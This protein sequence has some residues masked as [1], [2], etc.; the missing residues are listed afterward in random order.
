MI[1]RPDQYV[2]ITTWSGTAATHSITGLNFN[3][4]PDL[5][6]LKERSSTSDNGLWN[7][8]MGQSEYN[9]S[10]AT[11][12][13]WDTTTEFTSFDHNGFTLGN[14]TMTNQ[15]GQTYVA[16]CWRAGGSKGTFN[17]D[18]VAYPSA[19]A[20]GLDG[21]SLDPSGASIGTKQGFSILKYSGAS[22]ANSI[23][24]G[25]SQAP[26]FIIVKCIDGVADQNWTIYHKDLPTG[27]Y[28]KFTSDEKIDYPMFNDST[29]N[30][31][32]IPLGNDDQVSGS[33]GTY[34]LYAWHDVPGLQ[35]FGSYAGTSGK[36]F[37]ELGFRP[38]LLVI[39]FY[40]GTD[41]GS[42]A[43]WKVIDSER[44]KFNPD[45]IA[46]KLEWNTSRNENGGTTISTSEG[47]VDFLSNGFRII[48]NHAP[49]NSSGRNY[50]YMAWAEQPAFNLYGG[51]S[52]AR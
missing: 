42:H 7:S 24:H 10:N 3:A 13:H 9:S 20:A 38:A 21:G 8:V 45:G 41:V 28:L 22:G 6:W 1:A 32:T 12:G 5:V 27:D 30:S 33:S 4:K 36:T 19:A 37:V 34:I 50:I 40:D 49:F 11:N 23:S 48:D 29:P 16:W 51:Q 35:K 26:T 15:S 31:S 18:D 43:G 44:N 46:Q 39:K 52:N 14:S 17:I 25:L 2:G 47:K